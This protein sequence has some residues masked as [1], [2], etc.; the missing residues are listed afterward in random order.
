MVKKQK[1]WKKPKRRKIP[2]LGGFPI[3]S[4]TSAY[5][6]IINVLISEVKVS[7]AFDP[8]KVTIRP[9]E[10]LFK[11]IW[12]TGASS[13]VITKKVVDECV[14]KPISRTKVNTASGETTSSVYLVNFILRN[15]VGV[16]GRRVTEGIIGGDID[17]L[18]GMDIINLGDFAVTNFEGKTTFSFRLPST[19]Q[20]DFVKYKYPRKINK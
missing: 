5:N 12:D 3:S 11:A 6:G 10:L 7:P 20:I 8:T 13:S 18:I 4:F 16:S 14:L 19:Q 2:K 17:V 15:N 1:R 9:P